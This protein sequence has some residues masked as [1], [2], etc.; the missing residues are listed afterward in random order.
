LKSSVLHDRK[1]LAEYT[2]VLKLCLE[3]CMF[4]HSD[5]AWFNIL[6]RSHVEEF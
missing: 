3:K 6:H 2:C 5:V 4:K 1:K